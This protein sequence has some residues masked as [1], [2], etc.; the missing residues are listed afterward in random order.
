MEGFP[1]HICNY[2]PHFRCVLRKSG[3]VDQ[4]TLEAT[5]ERTLEIR[6]TDFIQDRRFLHRLNE[7]QKSLG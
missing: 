1:S 7:T 2:R 4:E 3:V 5:D 6:K